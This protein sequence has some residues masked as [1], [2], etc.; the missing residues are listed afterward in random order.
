MKKNL[1]SHTLCLFPL[2]TLLGCAALPPPTPESPPVPLA[3]VNLEAVLEEQEGL[4]IIW[5]DAKEVRDFYR[6][7]VQQKAKAEKD[8]GSKKFPEALKLYD[9]SNDFFLMVLK[10][11]GYDSCEY[12]LFEGTQII[13]L[14]NLLVADNYLKA[15]RILKAMGRESSAKRKWKQA[16]P[17][18]QQSLRCENTEWGLLLQK[19]LHTLLESKGQ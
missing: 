12:T 17:Y 19:E 2:L 3:K 5:E 14:P 15:G 18:V 8:F 16:L 9:T 6:G 4:E 11:I 1:L 7:G 13:F 10:Y